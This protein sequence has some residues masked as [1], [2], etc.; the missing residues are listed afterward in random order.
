MGDRKLL[1]VAVASAIV[2]CGAMALIVG[3]VGGVAWTAIGRVTVL[4]VAG[5]GLV[6]A[7]A[8]S[9]DRRRHR[10]DRTCNSEEGPA[11]RDRAVR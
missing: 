3:L 6:V 4:S 2:C 8:W 7:I 10:P 1:P 11:H 5:L 9:L